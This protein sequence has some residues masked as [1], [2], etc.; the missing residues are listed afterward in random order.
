M[1]WKQ[2][3]NMDSFDDAFGDNSSTAPVSVEKSSNGNGLLEDEPDPAAEFLA[4]EQSNFAGLEDEIPVVA[5]GTGGGVTTNGN[6]DDGFEFS[7]GNGTV[8]A[9]GGADDFEQLGGGGSNGLL[10]DEFSSTVAPNSDTPPTMNGS[11][12]QYNVFLPREEPEKIKIWRE[13]QQRRLEV[14][15]GELSLFY[16]YFECIICIRLI[17]IFCRRC[18]RGREQGKVTGGSQKGT[19]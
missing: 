13:E 1:E 17:P 9:G 11:G 4:R 7:N 2:V 8:I 10:D 14:K 12:P 5:E 15:G 19:G 16:L 18:G 3:S 6:S